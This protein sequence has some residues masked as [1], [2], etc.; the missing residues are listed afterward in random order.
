MIIG[1]VIAIPAEGRGDYLDFWRF[2]PDKGQT[3]ADLSPYAIRFTWCR[4]RADSIKRMLITAKRA[5]YADLEQIRKDKKR[6]AYKVFRSV[7]ET[8]RAIRETLE[9]AEADIKRTVL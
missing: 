1:K 7:I 2:I 6:P 9:E 8:Q 3:L 4:S 5:Y